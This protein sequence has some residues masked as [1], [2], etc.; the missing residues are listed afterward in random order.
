MLKI[1]LQQLEPTIKKALNVN[2]STEVGFFLTILEAKAG[3]RVKQD[4]YD[5]K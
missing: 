2:Q 5:I 1:L 3:T 4:K